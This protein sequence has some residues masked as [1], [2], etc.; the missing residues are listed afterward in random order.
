MLTKLGDVLE[1]EVFNAGDYVIRE[2]TVGDTFYILVEGEVEVT[3]KL[4]GGEEERLRK[5]REGE[6]FGEQVCIF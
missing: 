1:S 2:G 4:E 3:R 5:L 6:Y